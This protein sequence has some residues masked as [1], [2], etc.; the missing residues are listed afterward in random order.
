MVFERTM[1]ATGYVILAFGCVGEVNCIKCAHEIE[2]AASKTRKR[3]ELYENLK[4]LFVFFF[5]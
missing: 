1:C 2:K 3:L 4:G 5:K